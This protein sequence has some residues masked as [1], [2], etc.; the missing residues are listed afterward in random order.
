MILK[1][2][3][4]IVLRAGCPLDFAGVKVV[5]SMLI[6]IVD[7]VLLFTKFRRFSPI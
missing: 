6:P 1:V 2:W 4:E 7:V 3:M 5:M